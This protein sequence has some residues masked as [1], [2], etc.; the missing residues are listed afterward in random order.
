MNETLRL[1]N[2]LDEAYKRKDD[3]N[4][5]YKEFSALEEKFYTLSNIIE[6]LKLDN[7]DLVEEIVRLKAENG[8]L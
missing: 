2:L 7:K 4:I 8:D 1:K 6:G 3:K 5:R